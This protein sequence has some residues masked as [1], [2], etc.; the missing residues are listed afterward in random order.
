VVIRVK[1]RQ[2]V[3]LKECQQWVVM[4]MEKKQQAAGVGEEILGI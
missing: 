3:Q 1:E 4:V 2:A